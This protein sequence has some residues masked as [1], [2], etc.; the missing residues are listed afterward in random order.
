[1]DDLS[2]KCS[3]LKRRPARAIALAVYLEYRYFCVYFASEPLL[4]E[5]CRTI[6]KQKINLLVESTFHSLAELVS[7]PSCLRADDNLGILADTAENSLQ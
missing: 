3:S 2:G 6:V 1:M 4:I 7:L 5:S